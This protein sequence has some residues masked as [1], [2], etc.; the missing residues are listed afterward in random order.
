MV[1]KMELDFA[2]EMGFEKKKNFHTVCDAFY[3]R[4]FKFFLLILTL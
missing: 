4:I 2:V 3:V 1:E